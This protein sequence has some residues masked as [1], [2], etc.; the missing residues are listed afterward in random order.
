MTYDINS[1]DELVDELGGPTKL[2]VAYG[3]TPANI[4]N[5]SLRGYIPPSW[6]LRLYLE[7]RARGLTAHPDL[8]ELTDEQARLAF[9][10]V[11]HREG[12]AA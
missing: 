3:Y 4:S 7:L 9:A 10:G 2:A 8:F 1:I 12:A 6:H 5:W 11:A